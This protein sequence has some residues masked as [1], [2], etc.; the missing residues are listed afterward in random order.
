VGHNNSSYG[1]VN[2][3]PGLMWKVLGS[4]PAP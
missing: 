3:S 2:Y 1:G 4:L